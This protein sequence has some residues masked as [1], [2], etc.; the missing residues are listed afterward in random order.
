MGWVGEWDEQSLP[1]AAG[2]FAKD[3][4]WAGI[5]LVETSDRLSPVVVGDPEFTMP[6]DG[7]GFVTQAHLGVV[8]SGHKVTFTESGF[9][10]ELRVR[11]PTLTSDTNYRVRIVNITDPA[12]PQTTTYEEPVLREGDWATVTLGNSLILEGQVFWIFLDSLNSGADTQFSGGWTRGGNSQSGNPATSEWNRDNQNNILRIDKTDLDTNGRAT[13]LLSVTPNSTIRIVQDSDPTS[14]SEYIVTS[15]PTDNGSAVVYDVF[16]RDQGNGG[17]ATGQTCSIDVTIPI[18]QSTDYDEINDYWLTNQPDFAVMEGVLFFDGVQQPGHEN[19]GYGIDFEFQKAIVSPEWDLLPF[20][21]VQNE[22]VDDADPGPMAAPTLTPLKFGMQ[23]DWVTPSFTDP[24]VGYDLAYKL[25]SAPESEF[26]ELDLGL[27]L[28]FD[29]LGLEPGIS[30][31]FRVRAKN[32]SVTGPWS[33]IVSA[34]PLDVTG[35]LEIQWNEKGIDTVGQTDFLNDTSGSSND[36]TLNDTEG[37]SSQWEYLG[38]IGSNTLHGPTDAMQSTGNAILSRTLAVPEMSGNFMF[39]FAYKPY[40]NDGNNRYIVRGDGDD[41]VFQQN[42]N[43][44]WW[45]LFGMGDASV[46][47]NLTA[48]DSFWIII[49]VN[50]GANSYIRAIK[51]DGVTDVQGSNTAGSLQTFEIESLFWSQTRPGAG[52]TAAM[53]R[54]FELWMG[55]PTM[56]DVNRVIDNYKWKYFPTPQVTQQLVPGDTGLGVVLNAIQWLR[57]LQVP[58]A[59]NFIQTT[60]NTWTDILNFDLPDGSAYILR[61]MIK[62]A[63][64]DAVDYFCG[65]Y[66]ALV[67]KDGGVAMDEGLDTIA[68]E[69]TNS[70]VDTRLQVIGTENVVQVNGNNGQTWNWRATVFYDEIDP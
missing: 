9:A 68:E 3:G 50:N 30:Y 18:A 47:V 23:S 35:T 41:F 2:S 25:T 27:V 13:E 48:D 6:D 38:Q 26:R 22:S 36:F 59:I 64:Q 39:A 63:R 17:P 33:P 66:K 14:F 56:D 31:D 16:L 67:Y 57:D 34:T 40:W 60:D 43:R 10:Y 44:I 55:T 20:R 49:G 42:N 21:G 62:G 32:A 8:Y 52:D 37:T 4:Q 12:N 46:N 5:A 28:T 15:Q 29:T 58:L 7:T 19:D 24:L 51:E 1:Y 69:R 11:V 45:R 70:N 53:F 61:I 65:E 54:S